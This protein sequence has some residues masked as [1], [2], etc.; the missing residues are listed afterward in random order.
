MAA[1]LVF[2]LI[3]VLLQSQRAPVLTAPGPP[4]MPE[5]PYYLPFPS[6]VYMGANSS[7]LLVSANSSYGPYP[8]DSVPQFGGQ[9][10]VNKGDQCLI[11]DATFRN[12]YTAQNP[13]PG[14][15]GMAQNNSTAYMFVTAQEYTSQ[16]PVKATDVTPPYP[17]IPLP[18]AHVGLD[19]GENATVTIYLATS[20]RDL[21][22]FKIVCEFIGS[23]P[24]P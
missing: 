3:F 6:P 23:F 21:V 1:A 7:I 13:L 12:D 8:F 24:P 10:G 19:S 15:S 9:P 18:G 4:V 22:N 16:G 14:Q 11:I 5:P 17:S 20:H 2:I